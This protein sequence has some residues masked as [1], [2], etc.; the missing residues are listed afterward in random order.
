MCL[1]LSTCIKSTTDK[2]NLIHRERDAKKQTNSREKIVTKSQ[3][4]TTEVTCNGFIQFLVD[5]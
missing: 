2:P 3:N 5:N 1:L 4:G